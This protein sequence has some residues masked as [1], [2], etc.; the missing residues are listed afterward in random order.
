MNKLQTLFSWSTNQERGRSA[1][2]QPSYELLY[3][4]EAHGSVMEKLALMVLSIHM[5][6]IFLF[7]VQK[8]NER[9]PT[10]TAVS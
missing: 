7:L 1:Y 9:D 6:I 8:E 4:Q 10:K 2:N 5:K 3:Y